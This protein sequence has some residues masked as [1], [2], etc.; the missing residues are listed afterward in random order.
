MDQNHY[1]RATDFDVSSGDR[2]YGEMYY[3]DGYGVWYIRIQNIDTY[4]YSGFNED[5][6]PSENNLKIFCALEGKNILYD[7]DIPGDTL[8]HDMQVKDSI[9]NTININW[10]EHTPGSSW[11]LTGLYVDDVSDDEVVLYTAN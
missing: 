3:I 9:G 6:F 1:F 7:R 10:S 2:L 11:G 4:E 8:F 5:D